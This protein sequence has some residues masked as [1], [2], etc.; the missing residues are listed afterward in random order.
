MR[1][2]YGITD[3]TDTNELGQGSGEGEGPGGLMC[4]S[5][6]VVERRTRR[7]TEQHG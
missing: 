6:G 5:H 1:R 4:C 2:L 3:T 7:A